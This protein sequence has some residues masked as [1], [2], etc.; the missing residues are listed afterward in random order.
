MKS[1]RTHFGHRRAA[2]SPRTFAIAALFVVAACGAEFSVAQAGE[3]IAIAAFADGIRHWKNG[4][5]VEKY[6]AYEP[7]Q[8]REIADNLLI[9]Q[10]AKGGWP[11]NIDPL[12]VLNEDER[13]ELAAERDRQDTSF[14]N[15]AT[16]PEVD[17]L[18]A[19]YQQTNDE[20]YRAAAM[21][22]IEFI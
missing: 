1:A 21:R 3:P 6:A 20:R 11:P 14:D 4:H 19:A 16:Y 17:Y 15:R 22:G 2:R 5:N 9:Y 18:A 10:R 13:R 7:A 12:R 8:V